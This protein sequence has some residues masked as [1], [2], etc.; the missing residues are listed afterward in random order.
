MGEDSIESGV[1]GGA[2]A[3]VGM[4][5]RLP[6]A[7]NPEEFWALLRDGVDAIGEPPEGRDVGIPGYRG[8]FLD[9]VDEFDAGFF[10]IAPREAA[11]LDPQQRLM[12]E[13]AWEA[14]E[15]AGIVP[16]ARTGVFLGVAADDYGALSGRQDADAL[17]PHSFTGAHRSMTANRV[18]YH[19][20]LRG[21]SFTVDAGQSSSLVAVHLAGESLRSGESEIAFAG[22]VSLN[23]DPVATARIAKFGALSPDYRCFTFDARANGYVRGEGGGVLVLKRLSAAVADGDRVYCVIDGSAVGNDGGGQTLTSPN[24]YAQEE[25]LR[26]AYERAGVDPAAV[27]YVELH[28]TGT[29]VGDPIEAAA[30]G[31]VVGTAPGRVRPLAVGSVKTNVGHLEGAAGITGLLKVVLSIR[32]RSL[33]AGLNFDNPNPG[34]PLGDLNLR[35]PRATEPWPGDEE[36]LIA[37][38]SSFGMG[39]TNCHVVVSEWAGAAAMPDAL[40][41]RDAHGVVGGR[42]GNEPSLVPLVVSARTP[43]ALRAQ[44]ARIAGH[45]QAAPAGLRDIGFSL[46][47]TRSAMEYR[48]V[49]LASDSRS[50]LDGLRALTRG[51]SATGVFE[52]SARAEGPVAFVFPERGM[53]WPGVGSEFLRRSPA[54]AEAFDAVCTALDTYLDRP[55]RDV[56]S[57]GDLV[58]RTEFAQP[59]LFAFQV[60]AARMAET[61]GIVPGLVLGLSS[62]E[63]AAAHLAGV[64]SLPDAAALVAARTRVPAELPA[65]GA[66][67]EPILEEFRSVAETVG[68]QEPRIAV[69]SGVTGEVITDELRAAGHWVDAIRQPA[70]FARAARSAQALGFGHFLEIGADDSLSGQVRDVLADVGAVAVPLL[71]NDSPETSLPEAAAARLHAEG[72][73]LD[74]RRVFP[75]A[76]RVALP[77]YPFQRARYWFDEAPVGQQAERISTTGAD[78]SGVLSDVR[79]QAAAVLGHADAESVAAHRTFKDLGFDS[80]LL[81]ELCRALGRRFGLRLLPSVL[82]D[83]PTPTELARY[84][85]AEMSGARTDSGEHLPER[86]SFADEPVAVVGIGCRYPGNIASA[87]DLWNFVA[88]GGDAIGPF[89]ADRG[90]NITELYDPTPGTAGTTYVREGGF[91]AD[92]AGFDNDFFGISPR[93]ATAMDPQ[94]R[95]ALEVTWE[96]ITHAGIDPG[97]LRDSPT[98]VFLG[99]THSGYGHN[100]ADSD[101]YRLTGTTPSVISGRIAY[102]LGLRGPAV[103]LDTACS[104]SLVALHLATRALRTGDCSLALAGGVTVIATPDGFIEFSRQRGLAPD[105]RIKAFAAAADGTAWSEGAGVLVLEKLSDARRHGHAVLAVV[106]G[107]AVNQDGAGNGL[108]APSGQAQEQVIR[109]ALADARLSPG[110]VDAL[111]A[112]GTGTTLGD[113]IEAQALLAAYGRDRPEHRALWLGS[114]K[115]NIG[116]T[117]AAAGVAGAIKMIMAMR[118]RTVPATLHVDAPTPHVDWSAG[119]VRLATERAPWP[120]TGRARRAGVSA[121]GISGTNAHLILEEAPEPEPLNHPVPLLV[122]GRTP[123]EL[124]ASADRLVPQVDTRRL[125]DVAYTLTRQAASE[126]RAVVLA[127]DARQARAGLTALAREQPA[128]TVIQG[129]AGQGDDRVV[130]VFPGQG[131]QW[132]GMAADLLDTHPAFTARLAEC[133]SALR[134]FADFSVIDLLRDGTPLERVD[135]VQAALWAVMV[136]LAAAWESHGVRP[137]AVVGHSQGEIAAAC[138]AG[139]LSL[140]DGARIVVTRARAIAESLSGH[141]GM[142]TVGLSADETAARLTPG[143]SVAAINGPTDTVVAGDVAALDAFLAECESAAIHARRIPVDYA[144]HSP[145]VD[146]ITDRLVADLATLTPRA[147]EIPLYS[148]VT[149]E[150]VDTTTL[151][152][153]YWAANLRQ[154]VRFAPTIRRLHGSGCRNFVEVSPHPVLTPALAATTGDDATILPTLHRGHDAHDELLT[155][156][157]LAHTHGL[158]VGWSPLLPDAEA[159]ELPALAFHHRH[160]WQE[161]ASGRTAGVADAGHPL[162]E[163]VVPLADEDSVLLTGRWSLAG[164]TWFGDHRV[165]GSAVAPGTVWVELARFAGTTVGCPLIQELTLHTAL[166]LPEDAAVRVQVRVG[167]PDGSGV[168]EVGMYSRPDS[169]ASERSWTRHASGFVAASSDSPEWRPGSWPPEGARP[170]D[171]SDCYDRLAE[172]GYG[173]GPAFAGLRACW[174]LGA[175][176]YA[177]VSVPVRGAD[178]WS[179][180]A[181]MLLDAALHAVLA[182][183][184]QDDDRLLLPFSFGGVTLSAVPTDVLRVHVIPRGDAVTVEL[185]DGTGAPVGSIESLSLRPVSP[186]QL[187]VGEDSL[188]RLDWVPVPA[189]E[190]RPPRWATIRTVDDLAALAEFAD[191]PKIVLAVCDPMPGGL[192]ESVHA[193]AAEALGLVQAWLADPR[194]EGARLVFVT[195]H[196]VSVH[197]E[198]VA[199]LGHTP[200]W[201]LVRTAQAENPGRFGLVDTDGS[202]VT[203]AADEPQLAIRKGQGY[204]PRLVRKPRGGLPVPDAPAWRLGTTGAG[205]L[206]NLALLPDSTGLAPLEPGQ[207]RVSVRAAGVNFRDVL[208]ALG[209]YPGRAE[210]GLEGAG[211]VTG[212]GAGTTG[213]AVGDRVFGLLP[214]SLGPVAV[215]D[216]RLLARIPDG[217]S[218][219]QAASVPV[220][221]LT[222]HYG[223]SDLAAL[224]AGDTVLVHAAAGGVGMAA[225]QLARHRGAEVFGTAGR[226]KWDLLRD[227]GLADEHIASSRDLEFE[228]KFGAATAGRGVDVVL[229]SLAGDFVDASLRLM[230]RGGTFLEMGKTD[231]RD[232]RTVSAAHAGVGYHPYDLTEVAPE[233]LGELLSELVTLFERGALRPLPVRAWDVRRAPDALRT[234]SQGRH[235]GKIVLRMPRRLDP[236]GTVLITG[237]TG[238]L[239]GV[240]ARH[241][242]AAHDVRHLVLAGRQG[243][244]AAGADELAAELGALGASVTVAACDAADRRALAAVLDGIPAENPLTAVVHTAGVL[245]DGPI[246]SLSAEQVHRVLR[247]K[248]DVAVNLHELT[249]DRDLAA[250]VLYSSVTGVLGSPGQANYTAA[251]V[252]LDALAAHRRASGLPATSMVWGLWEQ[253]SNL[254]GALQR[255][256]LARLRRAGLV[257]MPTTRGLALFDAA[258]RA[259]EAVS[260]TAALDLAAC[261]SGEV[262]RALTKGQVSAPRRTEPAEP[263]GTSF[264]DRIAGLPAAERD[265]A[266]RDLVR[267]HAAVVL[268]HA[269]SDVITGEKPFKD[270]GFDSLTSVELRNRLNTATGLRLPAGVLFDHA[271]PDAL[272]AYLGTQLAGVTPAAEVPE[273]DTPADD[274]ARHEPIAIVGMTCRFPGG[275]ESPDDL[276]DLV[277]AGRDAIGE[278]PADRG[279]DLEHLYHPDPDRSGHSYARTGGFLSGATDFDPEFFG[280]SPHEALA[281]DPQQR[282]ILESTWELFERT[283]IDA[284]TLRGS[285]TGVYIGAIASGYG[286]DKRQ[287]PSSVDGYSLTGN[288]LSVISGRVAYTFGLEGP[289]VTVDTA[290]SSSL[291]A[292]HLAVQALRSGE[293]SMAIAGGVSV[294]PN[295]DIFVEFSRQ[296][297]VAPDGRCKAFGAAADGFGPAEGV[298]LLLVERLSEAR[299]H[300]HRV[301]AVVRGSATNSDGASNG[302]TAPNGPS[303]QRVIRA[304]LANASV[305]A[306]AVDVVEAHGTG[307]A[308]GDPIEAEALLA[309]YG[310]D[311]PAD[312]P[313]RLG[314]VKSNI[315]HT[316]AAAGVAGL[317][318]VVQAMRHRMLPR[319]LHVAEP[320]RD[321]DW[322]SGAVALLTEPVEWA[323]DGPRRAAVSSFG[324]SGTNAHVIVEEAPEEPAGPDPA[325]APDSVVPLIVSGASEAGLRAQAGRLA[326]ALGTGSRLADVGFTLATAR[327][328]LRH[329][330]VVLGGEGTD[331]VRALGTLA[332]PNVV[333]GVADV[334]G[335]TVFVFPG[336]GSEWAGMAE[337]LLERSPIF[338]AKFAECARALRPY[339]DWSLTEAARDAE[340]LRRIDIVQPLLFSVMVSLA[341]LWRSAGVAPAAVVGT[342]Q[343]EVAAAHV[344]G[345]LSL[346]DAMRIVVLRSRLFA[347]ELTGRGAVAAVALPPESVEPRLAAWPG[348][349][350]IAGH[351]GPNAVT[352]AGASTALDEFVAAC[353]ADGIRAKVVVTTVASHCAQIDP[354]RERMLEMFAEVS[355]L[356]GDVPFY[357][358]AS[359]GPVDTTALDAEY[360]FDNA[361]RP[362]SFDPAAR[363]LLSAGYRF[364]VEVSPHAVLVPALR[365]I[366]DDTA[367]EAVALNTLHRDHGGPDRFATAL[368]EGFVRGLP[369]TWDGFFPGGRRIDL[370]TYAFQRRRFWFDPPPAEAAGPDVTSGDDNLWGAVERGDV[371]AVAAELRID[372]RSLAGVVA[373]LRR[374]RLRTR[375]DRWWYRVV[376]RPVTGTAAPTGTWLLVVPGD[377]TEH[378]WIGGCARAL[379][380]RGARVRTVTRGELPTAATEEN[381]LGGVVSL[382]ALDVT[383]HPEHPGLTVGLAATAE[384]AALDLGCRLWAV[385]AGGVVTGR[386]DPAPSPVQA[387]IWGL[388]RVIALERPERWGGLIDLPDTPGRDAVAGLAAALGGIGDEDQLAVRP[389]GIFA[390]RLVRA[391]PGDD[392]ATRPWRPRGSVLITGGTGGIGAHVARWLAANG[393]EHV[394]LVG[395]RGPQAPGAAELAAELEDLG[396]TVTVA[397]C[398]VADRCAV[399]ALLAGIP[400]DLPLTAVVHAAGVAQPFA[401]VT[402]TGLDEFEQVVSGKVDGARHLDELL[403]DTP[404]DAFVLCS[405]NAGVWG[406]GGNG[407]YA[408][409]NAFLDML[410]ERRRARGRPATSIAWGAWAGGGM[411]AALDGVTEYMDRRGVLEM[412]PEAAVSALVRAVERDETCVA[413]ADIDWARFVPGFTSGRPSPLLAEL[414]EAHQ[415]SDPVVADAG[416][417]QERFAE[418]LAGLSG[419]EQT[420]LLADTV[421]SEAA[422]VLGHTDAIPAS[423][424]F[425][426]LGF[427]SLTAVRL[428]DRL[429]GVTGLRLPVSVVFDHPT[430]AALAKHLRAE[431]VPADEPSPAGAAPEE[432]GTEL[433]AA[434]AEE[435]FAIVDRELGEA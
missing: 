81:V 99:A 424:A 286:S 273:S 275:V 340:S 16:G 316:Q 249:A 308:L 169:D 41:D 166:V 115:T 131:S 184:S 107:S 208:I 52:G 40:G 251:N 128:P 230:P 26:L 257:R 149:T 296:R 309:T 388:G 103:T 418:K 397:A 6:R 310:R 20:G 157:A 76:A 22:G 413:V 140:D 422:T 93:E 379:T 14:G 84:L 187:A 152:G 263:A 216:R 21:P 28:G 266:L 80:H 333:S 148:T 220:A 227:M 33:V 27:Q 236:E 434:S 137:A 407:A 341:A 4:A 390:R 188:F 226:G 202:D 88:R 138:V 185:A 176:T 61:C 414:P 303:Q 233:R 305:A 419:A 110:D 260:V 317:I 293:C 36:R 245:D 196:A 311:R 48:G 191:P 57:D 42:S 246:E 144:S 287:V 112:H 320:S 252:F 194:W 240:L 60:A 94:Q 23:L 218:F 410:A 270:T 11:A 39:G 242:V 306:G 394:V 284:S 415:V 409:G 385:T 70:R 364:F 29:K 241:L 56:V 167:A 353:E 421:R 337:D 43:A 264:A 183:P 429:R 348:E 355:P 156:L 85:Y 229:N 95:I 47:T 253:A 261:A 158:T 288:V 267:R 63:Y 161:P 336:Q 367:T 330:A 238:V 199:G 51:E 44:A 82:F 378:P 294:M 255:A 375:A 71:R 66:W 406:S 324:I 10:G 50:A 168:R 5:C 125:A 159:V 59:A 100:S 352:V 399:A 372:D 101:G 396:A 150:P 354:L 269:T 278:F 113:P 262:G 25:V 200:V 38:V 108:T 412:A 136:S 13:L 126:H 432:S 174:R 189:T 65:E 153:D 139:A 195:R 400:G 151:T 2:I 342:S 9:R 7:A 276:W 328:A 300:G 344:A 73:R 24:R 376:W 313:L 135:V 19:L 83:H 224:S 162:A 62:G 109:A 380:D 79:R 117:Q 106:R 67:A 395:R 90:W 281:M 171:V 205:T 143:L 69:V 373:A 173:Y 74:W 58:R 154:T 46:A 211:V 334:R 349:L 322:S 86:D 383:P 182:A 175:E 323:T 279:W 274:A 91:L 228:E 203:L 426:E 365:D 433:D 193:A 201:G 254:T 163:G 326:A 389:S 120:E 92:A 146:G 321:I 164:Q 427:D 31:A 89:P 209:T 289:A 382:L 298:G 129:T 431:L 360:W 319:T 358:T 283:G 198:D 393:A 77:T 155:A 34:I 368:A 145:H 290:C 285:G 124:R 8:G 392:P 12:L 141:G 331:P 258:L 408:A 301:L 369:V 416:E 192:A 403:A 435:I 315:G 119:A 35:L 32:N 417:A 339:A 78:L 122:S 170:V 420:R 381:D 225:V 329:R 104:S 307:T 213:F 37:G 292:L 130:F 239:G 297:A 121:F 181:P 332:G 356:R 318:K 265:M 147:G 425:R 312:R 277:A 291:V 72:A 280:I 53:P 370:P 234:M 371:D 45:V 133:D 180:P 402:E 116:H 231:P 361:R 247:A 96:A 18:S 127:A 206:E 54:F 325:E 105:A 299:R 430:P 327:T 374:R 256:D 214:E 17:T 363:A 346:D 123:H 207:V 97:S 118:E 210:L 401:D 132:T 359:G 64:L 271:T 179:G 190:I 350:T 366:F 335:G 172:R 272:A 282:L 178:E 165:A 232:P 250:F 304:A 114:V 347:E 343:G 68:C 55:L 259:G 314:S 111:E 411:M 357:S 217:W 362:V 391:T 204:A 235:T 3:V 386:D 15:D 102:S 268:G 186:D 222:A 295:P 423:R 177:E 215:A 1:F 223:F 98:G 142:A 134:P 221:F 244:A 197:D 338:A 75:G 30:L 160:F 345:A 87:G 398:D 243:R 387:Q 404:L 212:I 428:R 405:S 302:L 237:G 219:E 49:V 384:L 351:N 377:D 248:V